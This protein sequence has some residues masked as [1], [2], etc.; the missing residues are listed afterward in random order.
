MRVHDRSQITQGKVLEDGPSLTARVPECR[1][2]EIDVDV[3]GAKG[4]DGAAGANGGLPMLDV[5]P[6][7]LVDLDLSAA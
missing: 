5:L 3:G 2:G 6:M 4:D 7:A 1:G